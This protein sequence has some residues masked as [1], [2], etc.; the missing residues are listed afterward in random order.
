MDL[1]RYVV[2]AIV[3]EKRSYREVA[4]AHGVSIGWIAKIMARYNA[5]GQE[6]IGPR[7]SVLAFV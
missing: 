3:L 1:A 7:G 2:Q 4:T 6:A 5:G